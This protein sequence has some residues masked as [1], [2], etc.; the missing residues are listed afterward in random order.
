MKHVYDWLEENSSDPNEK[1]AKE[2]LD[3]YCQ[4]AYDKRINGTYKWL[5]LR[6]VTCDWKGKRY[7]CSGA[8]RMGDVWLKSKNSSN[9]YDHRVDV[10][11]LSNWK[12]CYVGKKPN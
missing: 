7:I 10:E 3:K 5:E 4:P 9:Y 6:Q 1:R 11:E 8:S 2:Y 12:V